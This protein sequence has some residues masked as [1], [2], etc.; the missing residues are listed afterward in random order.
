MDDEETTDTLHQEQTQQEELTEGGFPYQEIDVN[1]RE[2]N[3]ILDMF[4]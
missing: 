1:S 4:G 3:P 2:E